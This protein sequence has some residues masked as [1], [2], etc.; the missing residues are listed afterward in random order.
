MRKNVLVKNGTFQRGGSPPIFIVPFDPTAAPEHDGAKTNILVSGA[1]NILASWKF[2]L[3]REGLGFSTL[4]PGTR[5]DSDLHISSYFRVTH[6]A[7][8]PK[9]FPKASPSAFLLIAGAIGSQLPA[10]DRIFRTPPE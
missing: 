8:Q 2:H 9:T 10:L 5:P 3:R 1:A 4:D 6:I 7:T